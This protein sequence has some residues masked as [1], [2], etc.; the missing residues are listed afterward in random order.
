MRGL[1]GRN[2]KEDL[3]SIQEMFDELKIDLLM[4]GNLGKDQTNAVVNFLRGEGLIDLETLR[5]YY[6]EFDGS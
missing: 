6:G 5:E 1:V 4:A 3:M 2:S